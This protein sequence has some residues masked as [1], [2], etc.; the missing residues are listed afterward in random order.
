LAHSVRF[1]FGRP[2]ILK[3]PF[4]FRHRFYV[5]LSSPDGFLVILG[6]LFLPFLF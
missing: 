5:V 4:F 2:F 6:L 3:L 1:C